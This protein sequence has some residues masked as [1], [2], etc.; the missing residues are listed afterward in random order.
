MKHP[1]LC[2]LFSAL[3]AQSWPPGGSAPGGLPKLSAEEQPLAS[4][5]LPRLDSLPSDEYDLTPEERINVAV[6]ESVNR[7]VV[8]IGT[9]VPRTDVWS[10]FDSAAEG[11]G[12]GS[13]LDSDGPHSHELP[14]H[15]RRQGDRGHAARRQEL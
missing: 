6:Y 11:A 3:G 8:N 9:K 10:L 5:R 1:F 12:S 4:A 15:R 13:V 7:S 14:R 2:C